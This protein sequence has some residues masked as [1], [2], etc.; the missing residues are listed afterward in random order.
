MSVVWVPVTRW[1][2]W[3]HAYGQAEPL[4]QT[5]WPMA[6]EMKRFLDERGRPP[7]SLDEL[8]RFSPDLD[9]SSLHAYPHEFSSSG[10]KRF[11]LRVNN[12]F[13]FAI[14]EQFTPAWSQPTNVLGAPTNPQ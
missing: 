4:V 6:H 9:F 14:D 13:A 11:F 10:A 1:F 7:N 5:V 12:R 3:R 8:A 2:A